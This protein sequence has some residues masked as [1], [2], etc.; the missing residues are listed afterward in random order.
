MAA[1]DRTEDYPRIPLT[2]FHMN[3]AEFL[4]LSTQNPGVLTSNG[5]DWYVIADIERLGLV[6]RDPTYP[7]VDL[8][9]YPDDTFGTE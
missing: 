7:I 5:Q 3:T 9:L 8:G 2:R 1:T 6:R 4:E